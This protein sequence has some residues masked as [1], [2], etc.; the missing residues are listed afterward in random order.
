MGPLVAAALLLAAGAPLTG[1]REAG[2]KARLEFDVRTTQ[3]VEVVAR[4]QARLDAFGAKEARATQEGSRLVVE[5]PASLASKRGEIEA[6]LTRPHVLAFTIVENNSPL[7]IDLWGRLEQD[8][9]SHELGIFREIGSWQHADATHAIESDPFLEGQREALERYLA[10]LEVGYR[11][12]GDHDF[13]LSPVPE[14]PKLWRTEYVDLRTRL[15]IARV[16]E[17]TVEKSNLP[18]EDLIELAFRLL[19]GDGERVRALTR[20]HLGKKMVISVDGEVLSTPVIESAIGDRGRMPM[21]EPLARRLAAALLGGP[22]LGELTATTAQRAEPVV[23]LGNLN[24]VG[25]GRPEPHCESIPESPSLSVGVSSSALNPAVREICDAIRALGPKIEACHLDTLRSL[26][27]TA[28]T[29]DVYLS[30]GKH[31]KAEHVTVSEENPWRFPSALGPCL[32]Q[33]M[34]KLKFARSME[35]EGE[36]HLWIHFAAPGSQ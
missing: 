32:A 3:L 33:A 1:T 35:L 36:I 25:L 17:A 20:G 9:R 14:R 16:L 34:R 11:A 8:P 28:H 7:M 15:R 4:A 6:L 22:L 27:C 10:G 23:G 31:R 26:P 21:S 12:D 19:P 30:V 29:L 5:L 24:I 2:P 13:S 18:G